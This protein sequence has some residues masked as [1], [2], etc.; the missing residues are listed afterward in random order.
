VRHWHPGVVGGHVAGSMF[1]RGGI[2]HSEATVASNEGAPP[3][4]LRLALLASSTA[5][6]SPLEYFAVSAAVTDSSWLFSFF[7]LRAE[8]A[9]MNMMQAAAK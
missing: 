1:G 8:A 9:S 3:A 7:K 5:I 2:L 6:L 4:A